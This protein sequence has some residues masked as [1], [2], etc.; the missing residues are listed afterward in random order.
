MLQSLRGKPPP[1]EKVVVVVVV[2]LEAS[3]ASV[4]A[5]SALSRFEDD[6]S[7]LIGLH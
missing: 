2:V 7:G 4:E 1:L 5:G 6:S 3:V